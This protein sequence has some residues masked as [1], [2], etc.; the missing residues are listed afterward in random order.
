MDLEQQVM[1]RMKEAMKSKSEASLRALR[2]IK[3]EV[4]K[5]KA[6]PGAGGTITHEGELRLLQK[7]V[8]QRRESLDIYSQQGRDDLARKEQE[9]IDVIQQFLPAQL[10]EDDL[11]RELQVIISE[12]GASSAADMGKV[13]GVATKSLLAGPTEGRFPAY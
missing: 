5:A 1:G 2:A 12:T 6:E 7:M 10:T 9:E 8:K 4:L 11:K 3:S 13:M